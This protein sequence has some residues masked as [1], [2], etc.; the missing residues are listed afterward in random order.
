MTKILVAEDEHAI[1]S[2]IVINL[3]RAGYDVIE[4]ENG[5]E[6]DSDRKQKE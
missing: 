1:R 5:K 6:D 3:K 4:A 2:F